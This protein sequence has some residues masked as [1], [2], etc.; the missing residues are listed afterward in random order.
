MGIFHKQLHH[1]GVR[2]QDCVNLSNDSDHRL[3]RYADLL[4]LKENNPIH[5]VVEQAPRALLYVADSTLDQLEPNVPAIRRTLAMRGD[6]AWLGIIKPGQLDIYATD[7][8]PKQNTKPKSFKIEDSNS[9]SLLP[10]LAQGQGDQITAI[11]KLHLRKVLYGLMTNSAK[12][13]VNL[14]LSPQ[15]AIALTGRAL[16]LRFLIGRGIVD[17]NQLPS[18]LSRVANT[19]QDCMVSS[20]ALTA[21]NKWLDSTFNG[22]LLPLSNKSYST[23]F[24]G[25]IK[26]HR[27]KFTNRLEEIMTLN[28][29]IAP[30]ASQKRF[31]W[32][33]IDFNH[34]PVGLMSE[35][36]E[37]LMHQL[38]PEAQKS[39]SVYY[40]P[41]HIADYMVEK[42]FNDMTG[43]DTHKSRVLD[44]ACGAG[45]FLTSSF[46]KLVELHYEKT[47]L[48]PD[49]ITIR[50]IL[51]NQ[52]VGMD[53]NTHARTLTALS[54]YLT[55][56]ELD[57]QPEPIDELKFN[58][59]E[60]KVLINV[61]DNPDNSGV[62]APMAGSLGDRI[63]NDQKFKGKFD[64]VIG[65]PPWSSL[66]PAYSNIGDIFT[67]RC[68]KIAK[69][70]GLEDIS[71]SYVNPD[72]VPDLPFVWG[73]MHWAKQ[74]GQISLALA[75]RL[76]FKQSKQGISARKAI[77]K[78]L[79][80]STMINGSALR[81]SQVWPS[82]RMPFCLM[83]AHNSVPDDWH[84]FLFVNPYMDTINRETHIMRIDATDAKPISQ[85]LVLANN[86]AL[87]TLYKG[88]LM[89]TQ[90]IDKINSRASTTI[91][92][93]WNDHKLHIGQGF[94]IGNSKKDASDF[95]GW[96]VLDK[97]Y[98]EHPFRVHV[99]NLMPFQLA[100]LESPRKNEIYRP[101]LVVVRKSLRDHRERG[102]AL[103]SEEDI[104]YSESFFGYSTYG[105]KNGSHL[106]KY[107]LV[108]LHSNLFQ[109]YNLLTS[110]QYGTDRDV[111]QVNDIDRFPFIPL[112]ILSDKQIQS[113][114]GLANE[115]LADP[116]DNNIDDFMRFILENPL[117]EQLD[118]T[119][120]QIYNLSE[121]EIQRIN[122][123]VA[124]EAP[125]KS[126][127]DRS[128]KAVSDTEISQ[129]IDLL[130][131]ELSSVFDYGEFKVTVKQVNNTKDLPWHFLSVT[132]GNNKPP[133]EVN[134]NWIEQAD[135]LGTSHI[136]L[137]NP[138]S[139]SL[140]VGLLNQYRFWVPSR[141]RLL[142]SQIIWGY[143]GEMEKSTQK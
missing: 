143:G 38:D 5:A 135:S 21:T 126:S 73:A 44:P 106:A 76:L 78:S 92:F 70:R 113:I 35:I 90:L 12:A 10:R 69:E 132:L 53:I 108:L 54:L 27:H 31:N 42:S 26:D 115:L 81:D 72:R 59:L 65:N 142:A 87:K 102:R 15:D 33:D 66:P 103:I 40:T 136:F 30:G 129:F 94:K 32:K 118:A 121:Y 99:G 97:H 6:Q 80:I 75:A 24:T 109:Y 13:L 133:V 50:K 79:S 20:E 39:T 29:P 83:F 96:P 131:T 55:A 101:P 122:D 64:L 91:K 116:K 111:L 46:R 61:H 85:K 77:F 67:Q 137:Y 52:I 107:L 3:L 4:R 2:Q 47:N 68:R 124:I 48:R 58:K 25:L 11:S 17:R 114:L 128:L 60:G 45:V 138:G 18:R 74:G 110:S 43:G 51:A 62:L 41:W 19:W 120:S 63:F 23:W 7:L 140:I 82:V 125:H 117:W 104:F 105:H 141:A 98:A 89:D 84:E 86:T 134:A 95:K 34:V 112:E 57:P 36:Y 1:Y 16:F 71:K 100:K 93:Y 130:N 28:D 9:I 88:S 123:I 119:V 14:E 127:I 37:E 139:P 49:R 56:L 8:Q 22:D